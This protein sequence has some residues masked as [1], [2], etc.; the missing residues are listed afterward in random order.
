MA[1]SPTIDDYVVQAETLKEDSSLEEKVYTK[2]QIK[3]LIYD[4]AIK[5]GLSEDYY[6]TLFCESSFKYNAIGPSGEIGVAQYLKSTWDYFNKLRG[7]SLDIYNTKHQL[8][9]TAWAWKNGL[10]FHWVC[11]NKIYAKL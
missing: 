11:Y 2:E 6:K 9:L 3:E 10:Q 4:I 5:E 7:T 8:E 1:I